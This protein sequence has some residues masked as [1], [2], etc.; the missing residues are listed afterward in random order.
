MKLVS[1][2]SVIYESTC[3]WIGSVRVAGWKRTFE[4]GSRNLSLVC[5]DHE[6]GEWED[7]FARFT[8]LAGEERLK[9]VA[10]VF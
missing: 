5:F 6:S 3:S 2:C 7:Q 10:D 8:V 9:R 4:I 1:L